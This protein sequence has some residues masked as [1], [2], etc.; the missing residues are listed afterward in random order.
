MRRYFAGLTPE[1]D[2]LVL[3]EEVPP[4]LLIVFVF[5]GLVLGA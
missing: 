2:E 5:G 1:L 3:P 4:T